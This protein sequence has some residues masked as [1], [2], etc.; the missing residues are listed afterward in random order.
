MNHELVELLDQKEIIYKTT[1]NPKEILLFCTSGEHEDRNPSLSFNL[2]KNLFQCWSC[3][4]RGGINKYL[5]S[6]GITTPFN[7]AK[8]DIEVKRTLVYEKLEK[9]RDLGK[10]I[11]IP[12]DAIP[13]NHPYRMLDQSTMMEMGCFTT[14]Q[15]N[16]KDYLCFPIYQFDE[17]KF[18]EGRLLSND[19]DKSKWNRYP[20]GLDMTNTLYPLDKFEKTGTAILVEGLLDCM[21][22]RSLGYLNT[23]CIFGTNGFNAIK[24]EILKNYGI[25]NIIPLM[26]GDIAG[27]RAADRIEF[28]CKRLKINCQK[29]ELALNRDPKNYS[30][31]ELKYLIGEPIKYDR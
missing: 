23:L 4:F 27:Q 26:D 12:K 10:I 1:N 25:V 21:Y 11:T 20:K 7:S 31:Q 22:L 17:L 2:T 30:Y 6:I 14:N 24:G 5:S 13:F 28:L 29:V 18:V 3:G 15:I 8:G 19:E 9:I 16:M